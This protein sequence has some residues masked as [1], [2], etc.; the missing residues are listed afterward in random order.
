[1]FTDTLDIVYKNG[2]QAQNVSL[3]NT[4]IAWSTDVNGKFKNPSSE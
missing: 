3:L 1:M 4:G 2:S